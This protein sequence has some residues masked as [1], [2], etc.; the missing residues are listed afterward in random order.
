MNNNTDSQFSMLKEALS[1]IVLVVVITIGIILI[2]GSPF[3]KKY[4][5]TQSKYNTNDWQA[6]NYAHSAWVE[7]GLPDEDIKVRREMNY[8]R[9]IDFESNSVIR[10]YTSA[11]ADPFMRNFVVGVKGYDGER[12]ENVQKYYS[13]R[14]LKMLSTNGET[15]WGSTEFAKRCYESLI[16]RNLNKFKEKTNG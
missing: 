13:I 11:S 12:L 3:E 16:E 15:N 4:N 5:V 14:Q 10:F 1:G 8:Y 2:F 6:T 7:Y 9:C